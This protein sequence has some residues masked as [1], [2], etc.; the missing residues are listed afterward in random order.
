MGNPNNR[1]CVDCVYWNSDPPECWIDPPVHCHEMSTPAH[2]KFERPRV[3]GFEF[4]R[5]WRGAD[6]STFLDDAEGTRHAD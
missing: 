1:T 6:G 3:K 4:C 5:H 2:A